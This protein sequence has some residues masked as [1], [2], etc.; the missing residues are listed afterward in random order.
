MP[1]GK[2]EPEIAAGSGSRMWFLASSMTA[3][4]SARVPAALIYEESFAITALTSA[5][6]RSGRTVAAAAAPPSS[7][8]NLRRL[9]SN[10]DFPPT[11]APVGNDV[12]G[13]GPQPQ[14]VAT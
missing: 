6:A 14:I 2:S 10:I 1:G 4:G 12:L 8:I 3:S 11:L 9:T 5:F 13:V 7:A